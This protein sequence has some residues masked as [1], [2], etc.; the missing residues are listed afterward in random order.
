PMCGV[1]HHAAAGYI[2]KLVSRGYRVAMCEQAE[3]ASKGTKLVKREVV[4]VITPGTA[5]DDQ[6]SDSAVPAYLAAVYCGAGGVG[7]AF[8]D[9]ST[10]EFFATQAEGPDAWPRIAE[11]IERFGA[12]EVVVPEGDVEIYKANLGFTPQDSL[13]RFDKDEGDS[14]LDSKGR[15]MTPLDA[16]NFDPKY[17]RD[18]LLRQFGVRE[19]TAFGIDGRDAAIGA[20][21]A[22]LAYARNTQR[23]SAEHVR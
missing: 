3:P 18:A 4:R 15:L 21:G 19:L 22:C 13:L 11:N 20:A 7:A 5:I 14:P 8:L 2:A 17:A 1:P 10:G 6:L 23:A 12:K 16:G 9:V